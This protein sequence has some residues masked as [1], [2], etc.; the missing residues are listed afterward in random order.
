MIRDIGGRQISVRTT[1]EDKDLLLRD[2]SELSDE[3]L[4]FLKTM[5]GELDERVAPPDG[6]TLMCLAEEAE[7]EREC[8][9][10]RTWLEDDYFMGEVARD[11]FPKLKEDL[12]E[13]FSGDYHEVILSGAIGWGKSFL[14]EMAVARQ[15]YEL[16][17][18]RN[19]QSS[20]GLASGSEIVFAG[21]SVNEKL[22]K[23]VLV[24]GLGQ[25]LLISPYFNKEF[26]VFVTTEDIRFPK[27]ILV[28]G[29]S[30][31][32][33]SLLGR[34][35]IG[36]IIDETNFMQFTKEQKASHARWGHVDKGSMLYAGLTRRMKS[37][38]LRGGK[39]PGLAIIVSSKKNTSAFTE[40]K[41]AD[42]ADDS[43]IFVREYANWDTRRERFKK[44]V[45]RVY[46]SHRDA[47]S[48][49]LDDK[50]E[51]PQEKM[52]Q[53]RIID[54]PAD[55]RK[56]FEDDLDGALREIAG[57]ATDVVSRY[58]KNREHIDAMFVQDRQHPMSSFEWDPT[59]QPDIDW[60][61]LCKVVKKKRVDG[62]VFDKYTP[63]RHP[64]AIRH[65]HI[66]PSLS[67]C[68][69]GFVVSHVAGTQEVV[70]RDLHTLK[71]AKEVL[72]IIE[73]DFALC[74]VPP[75]D[76]HEIPLASLRH[77]VYLFTA[78]GFQIG[79]V[80][81]DSYQSADMRQILGSKGYRSEVLSMDSSPVPY[82]VT[83]SA[84]YDGRL[85]CYQMPILKKELRELE[86]NPK[87]KK[88]DHCEKGS[89]DV[90]D[91]LAGTVFTLTFSPSHTL[92][93]ASKGIS[94]YPDNPLEDLE[95]VLPR[96]EKGEPM[97]PKDPLEGPAAGKG[98]T[99]LL[100]IKG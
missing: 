89:K 48:R 98:W 65:I 46:L 80:T 91:A 71:K 40:R 24:Q 31:A 93:V 12:I 79:L 55:F 41:V 16:S 35:V 92:M 76:G 17:C 43:R 64:E 73:V 67:D 78:H 9:D 63:L 87:Q 26:K 70:K 23:A 44:E 39:L 2:I 88:I 58:L 32:D 57:V 54:V 10:V 86:W 11:M 97:R 66:D 42:S 13:L 30:S 25:K 74:V 27:N 14:A 85:T 69:T 68:A 90:S 50:E 45:F 49:I 72:P 100:P 36:F 18:L 84:I 61:K 77:L 5:I 4:A 37:R 81:L 1:Q 94:E 96:N 3:E 82:D 59:T 7:Y 29:G 19:P 8:V 33:N 34:T 83:K 51:V 6:K 20:I 22:A 47:S 28:V 60:L 56:D 99:P 21:V 52:E 53:A 38:F 15:I 62:R 95:W 75:G